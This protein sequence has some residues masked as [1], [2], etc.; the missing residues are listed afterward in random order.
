MKASKKVP[1][2]K[3]LQIL[4]Y[5]TKKY[6]PYMQK[7]LGE[8]TVFLVKKTYFEESGKESIKVHFFLE[9]M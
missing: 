7:P 3:L 5:K 1:G 8:I 9:N 2:Q 6:K 4:R